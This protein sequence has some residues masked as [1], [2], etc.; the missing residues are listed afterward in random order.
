MM[1]EYLLPDVPFPA[2]A[3]PYSVMFYL[4]PYNSRS[5]SPWTR[6]VKTLSL[7]KPLWVA[8]LTLRTGYDGRDGIGAWGGV[9]DA[10]I[11]ELEGG[12]QTTELWD[13]RRPYPV[14]LRRYYSQFSGVRYPFAGGEEFSLGERFI[15][16]GE[17]E[18]ANEAALAG[19]TSMVFTGFRPGERVFMDGDYIGGD[20]RTHLVLRPGA[21]ADA[22]GRAVVRFKPPLDFDVPAG[23][24]KTMQP[25]SR[26]TLVSDDA[27]ANETVV[28]E[29]T[30]YTLD[31][32][33]VPN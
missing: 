20:G 17:A 14:G 25:T 18:P 9:M 6:A 23:A 10:W 8:R 12:A 1:S 3:R 26:F 21:V 33:E 11:A 27:G 30:E 28:G 22:D 32:I 19:A 16:P 7:A 29:A 13:F 15:I 31:F 2:E 24:A 4:Q 5:Q